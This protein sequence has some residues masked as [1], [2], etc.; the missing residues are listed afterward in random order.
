MFA[1][2]GLAL[3]M[4]MA[5]NP[6]ISRFWLL[7]LLACAGCAA[8]RHTVTPATPV[9]ATA[10]F[11]SQPLVAP[12]EPCANTFVTHPLAHTIDIPESNVAVFDGNGS[13][14]AIGDLDDDGRLDFVL[15]NLHGPNAI[16]WNQGNLTFRRQVLAPDQAAQTRAVTI[17]DADGDGRLDIVV[18]R[19][20]DKPQ[21]WRNTGNPDPQQ[22]F[23]AGDLPGV[24][25][26]FSTLTWGD[27][28]G[29]GKLDL[30]AASYDTELLKHEGQI[31]TQRGNG[32]GVFVYRP[33]AAG[34]EGTRLAPQADALALALP[35]LNNDGHPDLI[36]GNDF[37]RPDGVWLRDGAQWTAAT[38]FGQTTEN[39]MSLD[40]GD[41]DNNG[42]P[43]IFASDMKPFQKDTATMARW[44]PM[45]KR[46][47][48][49]LSADDPQQSE[50]VL[51]VESD[52]GSWHNQGYERM[53]DSSGWS[54]SS[55]FGDLDNDGFLDLYVVNGMIAGGL[56]DHLPNEELVEPNHVFHNDGHGMFAPRPEWGLD[57]TASGRGMSMA[58]LDGDGDLDIVVNN[59]RS[60]AMVLE[61]RLCRG[62]AVE[63][64]LRWQA[65]GNS[66]GI[67]AQLTL[68]TSA[69]TYYRD[70]RAASGYMSGD[71]ARVHFG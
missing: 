21:I 26:P 2:C 31:F 3:P 11:S 59:M 5:A 15:G 12:A 71:A 62:D 9:A 36:V 29:N 42:R 6:R 66:Y 65:T 61:N 38:P 7:M 46:M 64:D 56:F 43:E 52:N 44:L 23:V 17:V 30:V 27:L 22:R 70:V 4:I 1:S 8:P 63:V 13:G 57:L 60:P 33:G 35:D 34:F 14:L 32:V 51:Q 49:P 19:R 47:T 45:M 58:D 55:K 18:A 20:Y 10:L 16:F 69:G 40:V 48:R 54:W 25:H 53:V 37:N 39:T 28:D 41:I 68:A 50:N 67:G 24:N